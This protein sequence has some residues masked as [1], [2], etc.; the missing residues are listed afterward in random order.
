MGYVVR[1]SDL[2]LFP[3]SDDGVI[4]VCDRPTLEQAMY[5]AKQMLKNYPDIEEVYIV[6]Y[7]DNVIASSIA[8][9]YTMA[10]KPQEIK[11]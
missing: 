10:V 3:E 2:K 4:M 11:I 9:M 7:N 1:A 8:H 5:R 6:D